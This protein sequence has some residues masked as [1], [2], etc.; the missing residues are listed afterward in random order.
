ML[1]IIV[2]IFESV[3]CIIE[4]QFEAKHRRLWLSDSFN[5]TKAMNAEQKSS[6]IFGNN[7]YTNIITSCVCV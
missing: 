7:I 6:N 4:K 1:E 5:T 2:V 3:K